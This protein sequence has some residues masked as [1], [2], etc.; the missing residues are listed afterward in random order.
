MKN[1]PMKKEQKID[2]LEQIKRLLILGLIHSGVQGKDIAA[3]LN[4]DPAVISR[5]IPSRQIK[6]K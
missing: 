1:N 5:I 6:K 3:A 4:V 2:G